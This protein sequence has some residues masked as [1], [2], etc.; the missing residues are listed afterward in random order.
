MYTLD[1]YGKSLICLHP[2]TGEGWFYLR[3]SDT[4]YAGIDRSLGYMAYYVEVIND[5]AG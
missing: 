3:L 5:P 2:I 1:I 4:G